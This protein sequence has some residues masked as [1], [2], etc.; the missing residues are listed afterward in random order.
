MYRPVSHI[1]TVLSFLE[2]SPGYS[3]HTQEG[4]AHLN[5]SNEWRHTKNVSFQYSLWTPPSLYGI[6]IDIIGM[7]FG[8][9]DKKTRSHSNSEDSKLSYLDLQSK[10]IF[11][12]IM[13]CE[14]DDT[15]TDPIVALLS[16]R[17]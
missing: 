1:L 16:M 15:S 6:S 17:K 14:T 10:V 7:F 12:V 8:G 2:S 4:H 5:E 11:M 13:T 3:M 9:K